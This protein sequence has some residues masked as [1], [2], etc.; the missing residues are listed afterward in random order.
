[1]GDLETKP[2]TILNDIVGSV[3]YILFLGSDITFVLKSIGCIYKNCNHLCEAIT[4]TDSLKESA[5]IF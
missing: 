1:M 4:L 2:K 5:S 3:T